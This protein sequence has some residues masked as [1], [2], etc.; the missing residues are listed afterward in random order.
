MVT[1]KLISAFVFAT[2][3]VQSLYF[4]HTKFQASN[5]LVVSCSPVCV[6]PGRKPRRPVFSQRGSNIFIILH[7]HYVNICILIIMPVL[8]KII[9]CK[10]LLESPR[11]GDPN[12][13][14]QYM[15]LFKIIILIPTY[16]F[17]PFILC[18]VQTQGDFFTEKYFPVI[19]GHT[20]ISNERSCSML[21]STSVSEV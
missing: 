11:R 12:R 10:Y 4:F 1:A 2:Y 9:Y 3:I 8:H 16:D 17:P 19:F 20:L 13:Y 6:G 18:L 7:V 21:S 5:H 14:Q 15:I